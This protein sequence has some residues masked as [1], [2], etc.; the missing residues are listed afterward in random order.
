MTPWVSW[1]CVEILKEILALNKKGASGKT[2]SVV[3]EAHVKLAENEG[4]NAIAVAVA[5]LSMGREKLK[6]IAFVFG[7]PIQTFVN[8]LLSIFSWVEPPLLQ[9]L[10][11]PVAIKTLE[12]SG[13]DPATVVSPIV[14]EA[15]YTSFKS[16]P[17]LDSQFLVKV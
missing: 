10:T 17:S 9:S 11:D 4:E 6:V 1:A 7:E 5:A 8:A 15:E 13:N 2:T 3:S 12:I 16:L 14:K